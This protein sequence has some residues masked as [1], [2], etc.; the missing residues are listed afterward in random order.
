M[1]AEQDRK[2]A[3]QWREIR[4]RSMR[5]AVRGAGSRQPDDDVQEAI[6]RS[7]EAELRGT[8]IRNYQQ[9]IS[10][11]SINIARSKQRHL[12]IE[13]EH[14]EFLTENP[15]LLCAE[16]SPQQEVSYSRSIR[17]LRES[18][19]EVE[20]CLSSFDYPNYALEQLFSDAAFCEYI[21]PLN[22][23]VPRDFI[24]SSNS[25]LRRFA[26]N[27]KNRNISL[28]DLSCILRTPSVVLF[29]PK[30]TLIISKSVASILNLLQNSSKKCRLDILYRTG[31]GRQD[32]HLPRLPNFSANLDAM[33]AAARI[34]REYT[35]IGMIVYLEQLL[36]IDHHYKN[37]ID[38]NYAESLA[39][40]I[41]REKPNMN[42]IDRW[43][44]FVLLGVLYSRE[45]VDQ[46][47]AEKILS[48]VEQSAECHSIQKI[49]MAFAW[50]NAM[51]DK[52]NI[53]N[54]KAYP[55]LTSSHFPG[56][57]SQLPITVI[58]AYMGSSP[59]SIA[60]ALAEP[61]TWRPIVLGLQSKNHLANL[62]SLAQ[63]SYM[64]YHQPPSSV[65]DE[66]KLALQCLATSPIPHI[67]HRMQSV[68]TQYCNEL[69]H[70]A[71]SPVVQ[72]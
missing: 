71:D 5:A 35:I 40:R 58:G 22:I 37:L 32:L 34:P 43:M 47:Y 4:E 63:L 52:K 23:G 19:R 8:S 49:G 7:L 62:G 68:P 36:R 46:S 38:P 61:E 64:P 1:S 56:G 12:R 60:Y 25:M 72:I 69:I 50:V 30:L 14:L 10:S 31:L 42:P 67:N 11:A 3:V 41:I 65:R 57:L 18:A 55:L 70:K 27:L 16:T 2:Q 51:K 15:E 20:L 45:Q 13:S 21:L 26:N 6:L 33:Y 24:H 28:K 39:L 17:G 44:A 53:I 29:N 66:L 54:E 48:S 59:E 9:Y